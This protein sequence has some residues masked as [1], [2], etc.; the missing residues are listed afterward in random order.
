[1]LD[2]AHGSGGRCG[3]KQGGV[4][5]VASTLAQDAFDTEMTENIED[6]G[7]RPLLLGC[8]GWNPTANLPHGRNFPSYSL[9][10]PPGLA[11]QHP[12]EA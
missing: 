2:L 11:E 6:M 10:F 1:M 7:D 9:A 8:R 4:H 3:G 12:S 5:R